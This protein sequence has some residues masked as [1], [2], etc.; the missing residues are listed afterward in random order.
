MGMERSRKSNSLQI[1]DIHTHILPGIDDGSKG[2]DMSM[3]MMKQAWNNGVRKMIATPHYLP[4]KKT[5]IPEQIREMCKEA[6]ERFSTEYG[7]QMQVFP[8]E[9]LYYY[10]DLVNDLNK[11]SAM[12]LNGTKYVLVEFDVR[13]PFEDLLKAVRTIQ[14]NSYQL[15]L[16]HYERYRSLKTDEQIERLLENDVLLQSNFQAIEGAWI[17]PE[18]RRIRANYKK[19]Y[20]SFAS[21]DMHNTTSRPPVNRKT[22]QWLTSHLAEQDACGILY[23]NAAQKLE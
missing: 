22:A 20:I 17:D 18:I 8:G 3:Y 6:Q 10:S 11:G 9:E 1:F 19:G 12:T 21:S 4:W 2:W 14:R 7:Q 5:I 13:V 16:A 15:I 23:E